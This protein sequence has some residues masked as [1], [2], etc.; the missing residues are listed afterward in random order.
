MPSDAGE[1]PLRII[2]G[3]QMAAWPLPLYPTAD[4]AGSASDVREVPLPDIKPSQRRP[5]ILHSILSTRASQPSGRLDRTE[6]VES[7]S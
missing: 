6:R 3:S 7:A 1:N 5:V 4:I 2:C